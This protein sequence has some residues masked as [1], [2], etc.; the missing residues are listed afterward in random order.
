MVNKRRLWRAENQD[1]SIKA[2][3]YGEVYL[4]Y[5][6]RGDIYEVNLNEPSCSC[7]DWNKRSPKGGCKHILKVKLVNERIDALPNPEN[8]SRPYASN[9]QG[10]YGENWDRLSNQTKKRDN[11]ECQRCSSPGGPYGNSILHAHHIVPKSEGGEDKLGNLITLCHDC[12]ESI[13][14]HSIPLPER[15]YLEQSKNKGVTDTN[16]Q[17]SSDSNFPQKRNR[18][19]LISEI[20]PLRDSLKI[21]ENERRKSQK[22]LKKAKSQQKIALASIPL[23]LDNEDLTDVEPV[24]WKTISKFIRK[25]QRVQAEREMQNTAQRLLSDNNPNY[26]LSKLTHSSRLLEKWLTASAVRD[27]HSGLKIFRVSL[28]SSTTLAASSILLGLLV[29]PILFSILIVATGILWYGFNNRT[30]ASGTKNSPEY[31]RKSFEN[32][33]LNPPEIWNKEGVRSR[34]IELYDSISEYKMLEERTKLYDS[35]ARDSEK[36]QQKEKELEIT[37]NKLKEQLGAV[38]DTSDVELAVVSKRVLDWQNANGKVQ[39]HQGSIEMF[40]ERIESSLK[41]IR[42][43]LSPHCLDDVENSEEVNE[44]ILKLW[45]RKD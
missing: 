40:D 14:G 23:N 31:Y 19:E 7:P 24:A 12:H 4:V 2:N 8:N 42:Q 10:N 43:K 32:T 30:L 41:K 34:L 9:E 35:L 37:R 15:S 27:Q 18:A 38:P 29:N 1:L 16:D 22:E 33:G 17:D 6:T 39:V 44:A 28:F 3:P 45:N 11:W 21:A 25:S 36:L 13:H 26:D 5:G 20:K